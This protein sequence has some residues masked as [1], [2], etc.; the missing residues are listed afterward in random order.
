MPRRLYELEFADAPGTRPYSIVGPTLLT[1]CLFP[2]EF[3]RSPDACMTGRPFS[4]YAAEQIAKLTRTDFTLA[5]STLGLIARRS[6]R[7]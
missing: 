6:V 1:N 4:E 5:L 7:W 2:V 3:P